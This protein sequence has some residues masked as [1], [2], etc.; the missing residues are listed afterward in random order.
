MDWIGLDHTVKNSAIDSHAKSGT[1]KMG[2][3]RFS[4]VCGGRIVGE[5]RKLRK[6]RSVGYKEDR[7]WASCEWNRLM[8]P[9]VCALI[10]HSTTMREI[11]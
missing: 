11:Q 7:K 9:T 3:A 1:T 5:S 6:T 8:V 2:K 4:L 10:G